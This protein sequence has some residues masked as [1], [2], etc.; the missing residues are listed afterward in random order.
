MVRPGSRDLP[1]DTFM[2]VEEPP[3]LLA[4]LSFSE[5]GGLKTKNFG[6]LADSGEIA[7]SDG[8]PANSIRAAVS[9]VRLYSLPTSAWATPPPW[10]HSL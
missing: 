10:T 1:V 8:F 5:G 4:A 9:R 7:Q 6:S 3:I 2:V